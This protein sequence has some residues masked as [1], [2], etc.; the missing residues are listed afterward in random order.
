M[1]AGGGG[2]PGAAGTQDKA[3]FRQEEGLAGMTTVA[4]GNSLYDANWPTYAL[5]PAS[6]TIGAGASAV[7]FTATPY[8]GG[9]IGNNITVTFVDPGGTTATLGVVV[10]GYD[11]T[12]NLG[13]AA[14]AINSTAAQVAAAVN[15]A[16]EGASGGGGYVQQGTQN[17]VVATLPGAGSGLVA[18]QAKTNLSGA[19][20]AT[21][22]TFD[23]GRAVGVEP[24]RATQQV[25]TQ[26]ENSGLDPWASLKAANPSKW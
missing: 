15:G 25:D 20:G 3:V 21:V 9:L 18:A 5:T 8:Y 11:I 26:W 24:G 6:L 22:T 13:R 17:L 16:V 7:T 1:A 2:A 12:V 10:S 4:A 19:T 23:A 14:S